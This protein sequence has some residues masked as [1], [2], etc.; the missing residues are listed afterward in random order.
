MRSIQ[1]LFSLALLVFV[2]T[3]GAQ[4]DAASS[5]SANQTESL[6]KSLG[7]SFPQNSRSTLVLERDGKKYL[8]DVSAQTIQEMPQTAS[9]PETGRP[10]NGQFAGAAAFRQNCAVCHGPNGAGNPGIGTPNFHDAS[11]QRSLSDQQ[12]TQTIANG[13][14]RMPAWSGKLNDTQIADLVTYIR[15]FG[16]PTAAGGGQSSST[17]APEQP[18]KSGVYEAGDDVLVT[19]PSGRP[20]ARHGI[21]VNFT[22]R[23]VYDPAFT[24]AA[25]GAN[26]FGL[27]GVALPS[28]G[29][30]YGATDKLSFS[31]YRSP[32]LINR[33]IQLMAAYSLLDEHKDAPFNLKA[34]FS[35][36]GQDN[37]QKN[38]TENLEAIISRSVTSRAQIYVVPTMS[39]NARP[40]SQGG[41]RSSDIANL[42]GFNTFSLGVGFAVDIRPTVALLAEVIPTL[43]NGSELGIHRP[44]YSFGIQKKIW[45]HAFT[46]GLTTGPG[47]TVSQRAGTRAEFL[48]DPGADTPGGLFLGFDLTR[49]IH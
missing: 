38:F 46:L 8:I 23:F 9:A 2:T 47:T 43:A 21:Y 14:G 31:A 12:M 34:R 19:L 36:E 33:P 18:K 4:T 6:A 15:S 10:A 22:H 28:F 5:A 1:L 37:F 44:A 32:S 25:R 42:P 3:A 48:R 45:R 7:V 20:T 11:L 39:F 27:D 30:T 26:L 49:Q 17:S 24:G 41:I 40:L 29:F 35:V 13:K 16:P